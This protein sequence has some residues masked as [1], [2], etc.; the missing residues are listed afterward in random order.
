MT[1]EIL[2]QTCDLCALR[3]HPDDRPEVHGVIC[4]PADV[5]DFLADGYRMLAGW[6]GS[7]GKPVTIMGCPHWEDDRE[8]PI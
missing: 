6:V 7:D 3:F 5:E 8:W 1:V 2:I 4:E